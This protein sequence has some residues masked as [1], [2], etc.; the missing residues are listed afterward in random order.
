MPLKYIPNFLSIL[1]IIIAPLFIVFLL[2]D[3]FVLNLLSFFLFFVGSLSDALD[4]YIARK[5]NFTTE[6]GKYLDPIADKILI[7]SGF[8]MLYFFYS[9]HIQLWMLLLIII[10]D[11]CITMLRILLKSKGLEM[12]TSKFA[13]FK[14]L[15]QILVIHIILLFHIF[16]SEL[17][18]SITVFSF[19]FIEL[20]MIT[21]VLYTLLS[22]FSYI[23]NYSNFFLYEKK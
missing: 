6:I 1:R 8:F 14:T 18:S 23:W 20:L 13:K 21:C 4:G 7:L 3:S 11:F 9:N 17:I 16:W 10:R 19:N 15:Y 5:Y 12:R 2:F 22:G